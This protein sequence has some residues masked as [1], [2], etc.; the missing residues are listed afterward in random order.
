MI[1]WATADWHLFHRNIRKYEPSRPEDF[2]NLLLQNWRE[3]VAPEDVVY[4]LGDLFLGPRSLCPEIASKISALPGHKIFVR[5]N[6]DKRLSTG[7]LIQCGFDRVYPLYLAL[8]K[9]GW[10]LSHYPLTNAD[11]RYVERILETRKAFEEHAC[12]LHVHGHVHSKRPFRWETPD[13]I[14]CCNVS[15]EVTNFRPVRLDDLA[16]P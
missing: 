9:R 14:K 2:E 12:T 16:S 1:E 5:G 3:A 15:V 13:G 7:F 8:P 4:F 11:P 10:L 6:H